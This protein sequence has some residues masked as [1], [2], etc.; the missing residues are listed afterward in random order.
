MSLRR[1]SSQP[2]HSRSPRPTSIQRPGFAQSSKAHDLWASSC[3]TT[4][5][6]VRSLMVDAEHQGKGIG[7]RAVELL[8]AHLQTRPNARLLRTSCLPGS[9]S[10]EGF[11]LKLGFRPTGREV[12]GLPELA[13]ELPRPAA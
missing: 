12:A 6:F 10:P 8:V 7:R 2:T 1:G 4:K 9:G 11:Y 3:F 5:I 13:L